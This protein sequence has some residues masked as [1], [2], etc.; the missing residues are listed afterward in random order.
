MEST[1]RDFLLQ[2]LAT[3]GVSGYE[4]P[5]QAVV[6]DYARS[7][8]DDLQT[9][10]HGNLILGSNRDAAL[11]VMLAGHCDQIGLIV[12]HIDDQGFLFVQTVGG[13]DPQQLVGQ[14][15]TVWTGS[16]PLPGVIARKPIHLLEEAER[17][18]V[19][20]TDDM[21]I[22]IGA[23][24]GAEAMERVRVG[25]SVTLRLDHHLL[26]NNLV[27]S[28][29]MDNRTGL[30]VVVEAHRRAHLAGL[31][32][33]LFTASTVQEEIGLRGARTAA[34]A[35]DPHVG[36]AVD[37][38][39][40]TDCPSLDPRQKGDIRLGG[41]PVISRGPNINPR[42]CQRLLET[43]T[44]HEIATQTAALGRAAPND[45]NALQVNR[46]GVAT[47]LVGVPNRYMHSAVEVC[48]LEDL[49]QTAELLARFVSGIG[50]Q[51]PGAVQTLM[52]HCP[53]FGVWTG[54][55]G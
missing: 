53:G 32:C 20:K 51:R 12:S 44:Q 25:D 41:G 16:G 46:Q 50:Q 5:V 37:V 28:P 13:W 8:V 10:L 34:F 9:D 47:G 52:G 27:A 22:D 1:A 19:V 36:I 42:I 54:G 2:L 26:L 7:F 30:W 29:G 17:K 48:S 15:T 31:S 33:A 11:R 43:G 3:P 45:S 21:W 38:T 4:Q 55:F 18:K 14:A 23:R 40:A 35:I 39:H 6:R 49:D 24:S